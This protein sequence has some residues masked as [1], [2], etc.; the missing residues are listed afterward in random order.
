[1]PSASPSSTLG[2]QAQAALAAYVA[3]WADAAA[4]EDGGNYRDSR[5]ER[6]I[7]GD[8]LMTISEDDYVEEA[9]GVAS[10]G[11]PILH[12]RVSAQ[13]LNGDPPTVTVT[14]CIDF[15]HFIQYYVAT[16]KQYGAVQT[17]LSASTS[18]VTLMNGAWMVTSAA[19]GADGSC[20]L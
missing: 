17:G 4:V 9:H 18:T 13:N 11:M 1:M 6:H 16:G 20:S 8:L 3:A 5:L 10:R 2:P 15:R 12:P 14:D 7:A 19:T